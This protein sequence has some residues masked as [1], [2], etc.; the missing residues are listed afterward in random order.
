MKS[1][2]TIS[3]NRSP[4]N[5]DWTDDSNSQSTYV[6]FVWIFLTPDLWGQKRIK[7]VFSVILGIPGSEA[8]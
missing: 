3:E 5:F 8:F 6:D 1:S 2:D 7:K 4:P